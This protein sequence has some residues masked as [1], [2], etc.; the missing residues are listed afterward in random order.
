MDEPI[1]PAQPQGLAQ[2]LPKKALAAV[3][4]STVLYLGLTLLIV[5]LGALFL[6]WNDKA[7]PEAVIA[8]A[9]VALG[10]LG[11]GVLDGDSGA[12]NG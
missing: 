2:G 10:Y 7:M 6:A 9:G 1:Q 12:G 11:K 3:T 4:Q 5:V 8:L